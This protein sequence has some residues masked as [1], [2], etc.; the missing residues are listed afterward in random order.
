[1]AATESSQPTLGIIARIPLQPG[2]RAE[3]IE[4]LQAMLANVQTEL[5]TISYIV[6]EDVGNDD[7][8]WMYE[9]YTDQAAID[10]HSSSDAMKMLGKTLGGLL[11][12]RPELT[13]LRP[14]G[15]KGL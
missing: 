3:A 6:H 13:M 4:G 8:L 11:A 12:A 15:G 9:L 14:I 7:A 5:G 1:M 2:K 10:L